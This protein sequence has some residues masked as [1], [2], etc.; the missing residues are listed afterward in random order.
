M[1][2]TDRQQEKEKAKGKVSREYQRRDA[3]KTFFRQLQEKKSGKRAIKDETNLVR[4][5]DSCRGK[6][7]IDDQ[8]KM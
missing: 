1:I 6:Y 8:D 2:D 4:A 3:K 5:E 7:H